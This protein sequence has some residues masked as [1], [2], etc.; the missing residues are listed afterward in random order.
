MH[1]RS[2]GADGWNSFWH[3]FFG[4]AAYQYPLIILVYVAYQLYFDWKNVNLYVDLGEFFI[5]LGVVAGLS[6]LFT[7]FIRNG[8]ARSDS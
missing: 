6:L 3:F 2:L 5:G 7:P 4:A 8:K 1:S